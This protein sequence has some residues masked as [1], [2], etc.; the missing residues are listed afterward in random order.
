MGQAGGSKAILSSKITR[1]GCTIRKPEPQ[2]QPGGKGRAHGS[3]IDHSIE[4]IPNRSGNCWEGWRGGI[5]GSGPHTACCFKKGQQRGKRDSKSCTEKLRAL[6][7]QERV[8]EANSG[9]Q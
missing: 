2:G 6:Y 1:N 4:G 3:P 8:D 9:S 7:Q 5:T